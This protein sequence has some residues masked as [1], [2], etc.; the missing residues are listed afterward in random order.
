MAGFTLTREISAPPEVVF[1]LIT[2]LRRIPEHVR[3]IQSVEVL[4]T[5]EV[6]PG[7]RFRETR[8]MFK[9]EATEEMEVTAM[10]A[11]RTFA[12]A[13]ESHGCRFL[14]TWEL[15]PSGPGTHLTLGFEARP[16]TVMARMLGFLTAPMIKMTARETEMDLDDLKRAAEAAA[17]GAP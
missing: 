14:V 2:D 12:V 7:T 16:R 6:R 4:D 10:E 17:S 8:I 3:A 1:N 5:G 13:S 15:S 9:K 11:P